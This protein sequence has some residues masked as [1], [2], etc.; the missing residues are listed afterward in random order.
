MLTNVFFIVI[1]GEEPGESK[2]VSIRVRVI[3]VFVVI[4]LSSVV[5]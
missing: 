3:F 4:M 5:S 1:R 2:V